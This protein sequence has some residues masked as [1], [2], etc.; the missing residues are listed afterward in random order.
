MQIYHLEFKNQ[1]LLY[2]RTNVYIYKYANMRKIATKM[3][4]MKTGKLRV[5]I[6]IIFYGT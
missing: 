3:V 5:I 6:N 1:H 2:A 4:S